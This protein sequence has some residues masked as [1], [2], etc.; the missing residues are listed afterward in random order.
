MGAVFDRLDDGAR[1]L[2]DRIALSPALAL[3]LI[4]LL[5]AL[6]LIPGQ[7]ELPL[8]D[9]DE[10]R[11]VQASKQMLETGDWI[12]P[13]NLDAPRWKKPVGIYW[14]QAGAAK[15]TGFGA[16]APLWVYRLPSSLGVLAA[17]FLTVWA[18][19]PVT[20]PGPAAVA[21]L[22]VATSVIPALEGHIA[23][24]DAALLA[25]VVLA[26][27]A[28]IRSLA[29]VPED[30]IGWPQALFWAAL[31]VG[32]LIKGPI[33]LIVAGGTLLW[34]CAAELSIDALRRTKPWP[35]VLIYLAL[36][37][38]WSIAIG[39]ATDWGFYAES[40][41]RDLL[42]KVDGAAEGHVGP[43]G[44]YLMT[45]W[46]TFWPWAPL[47]LLALPFAWAGRGREDIRLIAGWVLPTWAVFAFATTKLP[48]Y[49]MP[50]LPAVG[51]LVGLWLFSGD[52][53]GPWLRWT[54]A[55]LFLVGGGALAAVTIAAPVWFEGGVLPLPATLAAIGAGLT[56]AGAL[57]IGR[58]TPRA[59]IPLGIAALVLILPAL[60]RDTAPRLDSLFL[61]PRMAVLDAR[62]DACAPFPLVSHGYEEL[63]L[64]FYAGSDTRLVTLDEAWDATGDPRPGA[65]AF[66]PL[67]AGEELAAR[68]GGTLHILGRVE[69]INYNKGP[70]PVTMALVTRADDPALAPCLIP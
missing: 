19:R 10:A 42:G 65:R 33:V 48:H 1:R 26:Q 24:T 59:G 15:I 49:T 6:L 25:T 31:A 40:V 9:R 35:G 38:P 34:L 58:G 45:V 70:D 62:F 4:T 32:S 56:C 14:L 5:A 44:Y 43:P 61:S 12:E 67:E 57:A 50:V 13:R 55:A 60:M 68:N 22:V 53:R 3:G 69:G 37:L 27:G 7:A 18:F 36:I 30:G 17:A 39:I 66:I 11:Y 23:K 2:L 28:L 20:G 47:A 41:G 16:D 46:L 54:A 52:R 8:T 51:A 29:R 64:A 63:S 21:G